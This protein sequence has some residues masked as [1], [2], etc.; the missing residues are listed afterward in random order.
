MSPTMMRQFWSLVEGI[1]ANIPVALDDNSLEQWLLRQLR[2]EQAL[3][4]RETAIFSNYI[5][6][7]LPLIR[8]LVQE[9]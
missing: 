4:Y 6:S 1:R 8:E 5:H 7:R 2:S 3:N 9:C